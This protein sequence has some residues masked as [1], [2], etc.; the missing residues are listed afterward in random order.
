MVSSIAEVSP[1]NWDSCSL[2]ATGHQQF[3]PF[4]SHGFLSSLEESGSAVE[5]I[6]YHLLHENALLIGYLLHG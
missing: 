6:N 4:L 2:D 3:N 1:D 5:V